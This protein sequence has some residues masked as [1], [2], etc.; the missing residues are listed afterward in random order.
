MDGGARRDEMDQ[1]GSGKQLAI[2]VQL[3]NPRSRA[4]AAPVGT[5]C[6]PVL[7]VGIAL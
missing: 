3:Q 2:A 1:L 7:W 5:I 4:E 6:M